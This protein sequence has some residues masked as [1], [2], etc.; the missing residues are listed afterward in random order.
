MREVFNISELRGALRRQGVWGS[1]SKRLLQEWADHVR[2]DVAHRVESGVDP[3]IA[4]TAALRA[5][6]TPGDLATHASRELASGSWLGRHPWV[7]G[8]VIPVLVWL[9]TIAT[10][11]FVAVV[12]SVPF[13]DSGTQHVNI[14]MLH[15]WSRVFNCLPWLLSISWL[16]RIAWHMPGGW[17]LFAISTVVLTLCSTALSVQIDPPLN[18]PGSGSCSIITSGPGGLL[19]GGTLRLFLGP[20]AGP[21]SGILSGGA[22][23]FLSALIV[24][25]GVGIR[26]W[27]ANSRLQLEQVA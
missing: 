25:G 14:E 24:V 15:G 26:F 22:A 16:A 3:L 17:K 2:D 18:G 8:L 20:V 5:L 4:E 7:A 13:A 9:L 23:W 27:A 11:V 10:Q 12:T 6:G 19:L 21:W 1:R